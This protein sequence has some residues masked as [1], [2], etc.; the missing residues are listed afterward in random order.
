MSGHASI[1]GRILDEAA[2][3]LMRLHATSASAA[4]REACARW[5]A[6]SP[7]HAEAWARAERLMSM[8]GRLPPDVA[9]QTL[10]RPTTNHGRRKAV[11][12]IAGLLAVLPAAWAASRLAPWDRWVASHSTGPGEQRAITLADGTRV[13]LGAASAVDIAFDAQCRRVVLRAGEILVDTAKDPAAVHRPFLVDTE[14]GRLE[15]LGTRFDVLQQDDR[16]RVAVL[17]GAVRVQ[18]RHGATSP[19]VL[20][21]GEQSVLTASAVEAPTPADE[22]AIAWTHGMLV[23]DRMPLADVAAQLARYRRGIVRCDPAIAALPV[24]GALPVADTDRTLSM[25]MATYPVDV[26]LRTPWWVTL[27]P[28]TPAA[29]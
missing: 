23:A 11:A 15:A 25:L 16:I 12:R 19:R 1:D 26:V 3:W 4:D 7:A 2:N 27:V 28:R 8:L 18:P 20:R 5:R 22:S 13:T 29:G 14:Q 9:M 24:S 21:A 10:G 17:E 6:Q